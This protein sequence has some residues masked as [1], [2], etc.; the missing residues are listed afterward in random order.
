MDDRKG[1][2]DAPANPSGGAGGAGGAGGSTAASG[3]VDGES[4]STPRAANGGVSGNGKGRG[5]R[6]GFHRSPASAKRPRRST[7][8]RS[9]VGVAEKLQIDGQDAA[10]RM[11]RLV[12][13]FCKALGTHV[14]GPDNLGTEL[15]LPTRLR[16]TLQGL[17]KGDSEKQIAFK[18]GI[19]QHTV[20]VY[21]K[22]LYKRLR[23]SSRGELMAKFMRGK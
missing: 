16:Q 17:I 22:Q 3:A 6:R 2:A 7:N 1:T 23:V 15:K 13:E 10:D 11:R 21:V 9:L 14:S 19:S 18:L 12:V 8:I 20:H 4:G 5:R